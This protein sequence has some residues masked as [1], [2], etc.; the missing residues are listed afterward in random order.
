M[1]LFWASFLTLIA[2]GIGF[3]VRGAILDDWGNQFGFTQSELGTITGGGLIGFGITI[4]VLSFFADYI[5]YGNLMRLAFVLHAASAV[6]TFLATPLFNTGGLFGWNPR[7][8][9]YYCLNIGMWLFAFGN[10]TCEAVINPLTATLFP[11]NKTKWLNILHAG[12]PAGLILGALIGLGFEQLAQSGTVVRWEYKLAVFL[13]PVCLYGFFTLNRA[14]PRSEA[15]ASGVSL[16]TMVVS[17]LSPILLFLF[18]IHAMVGYVELGTDSWIIN[19]TNTV[20][21]NKTA[22]LLAFIWTNLLM[23][24]L[25]FFAGSIAHAINPLG[26]LLMS[27]IL[28][29]VGLVLLGIPATKGV[30]LWLGAVTIYGLGKTFYWGTMLGVISERFPKSGALALGISGGIGMLSAGILG[31]PGIG[32][33]QDY[34]TVNKLTE[35]GHADTYARYQA[36]EASRFP[37]FTPIVNSVAGKEL[38]PPIAGLDNAKVGILENFNGLKTAATAHGTAIDE[39]EMKLEKEYRLLTEEN[40]VTPQFTDLRNWWQTTGRPHEAEDTPPIAEAKL[41]GSKMALLATAAVP[42]TMAICYLLLLLYFLARGGYKQV[43]L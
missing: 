7:D 8:T 19:I 24:S 31:G 16:A 30:W 28:G 4:I 29:C 34:F 10:G 32:Y 3:S 6:V 17:L 15:S 25:R 42:A 37:V 23:F 22:A 12:W 2:A 40:R 26:L 43:H 5:G 9:A 38:L 41:H 27:A 1:V 39:T 18:L 36:P 14:F 13:L 20:L 21:D 35:S 11:N 33:K